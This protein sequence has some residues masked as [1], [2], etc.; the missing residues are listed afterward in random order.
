MIPNGATLEANGE[1]GRFVH[2]IIAQI[3]GDVPPDAVRLTAAIAG[4]LP[5]TAD[6]SATV[7]GIVV[8]PIAMFDAVRCASGATGTEISTGIDC[9]PTNCCHL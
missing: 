4:A 3:G 8:E 2:P 7:F 1:P 6:P 9:V 5:V